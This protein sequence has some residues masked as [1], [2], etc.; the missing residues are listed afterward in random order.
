MDRLPGKGIGR[1]INRQITGGRK[2]LRRIREKRKKTEQNAASTVTR[3][4]I[5][6]DTSFFPIH[7]IHIY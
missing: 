7:I 6:Q 2:R 3:R 5:I 4:K 1:L